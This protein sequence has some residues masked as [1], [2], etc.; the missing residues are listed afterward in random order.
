MG[1]EEL[2]V[3]MTKIKNSEVLEL[4]SKKE[5]CLEI[6][7]NKDLV[8][9]FGRTTSGKSST[10]NS[11]MGTKYKIE[12]DS[13]ELEEGSWN[14]FEIGEVGGDSCTKF[15]QPCIHPDGK[16]VF[17]DTR[18]YFDT[19]EDENEEIVS[20]ILIEMAVK[21]A[22]SVR[23]IM[24]ER[25]SI[26]FQGLSGF[27]NVGK[28]ITKIAVSS[29]NLT[30]PVLF[31]FNR[32]S[33]PTNINEMKKY[34]DLC[35]E[36][37]EGL[38]IIEKIK[39]ASKHM[40]DKG[41]SHG[42]KE[43]LLYINLIKNNFEKENFGYIDPTSP[44][45]INSLY[46]KILQL[47]PV[48]SNDLVFNKSN[49]YRVKF[50]T[51][52]EME[53]LSLLPI[54]ESKLQLFEYTPEFLNPIQKRCDEYLIQLENDFHICNEIKKK[55]D[56]DDEDNNKL[57]VME[58]KYDMNDVV[59]DEVE[60]QFKIS[61][62]EATNNIEELKK[63]IKSFDE[64]Y[65]K[66]FWEYAFNEHGFG[67]FHTCEVHYDLGIPYADFK[68]YLGE[69]THRSDVIDIKSPNFHVK[70]SSANVKKTMKKAGEGILKGASTGA[71]MTVSTL[72]PLV[73]VSSA[74]GSSIGSAIGNIIIGEDCYGIIKI[75]VLIK[76]I[77][78]NK[79]LLEIKQRKLENI[80]NQRRE[81]EEEL[82]SLKLRSTMDVINKI[83]FD[84]EIC[85]K[86]QNQ[87]KKILKFKSDIDNYFE[88]RKNDI[89]ICY[90]IIQKLSGGNMVSMNFS[91]IY[92]KLKMILK[93]KKDNLK[94]SED[95]K[96]WDDKRIREDAKIIDKGF[97]EM[98]IC[99]SDMK[100]MF[101]D[102][103]LIE[104]KRKSIEKI[105][106][107]YDEDKIDEIIFKMFE[108]NG[109]MKEEF[110]NYFNEISESDFLKN[111]IEISAGLKGDE[112][113]LMRR[114]DYVAELIIK[115]RQLI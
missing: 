63:E 105:I 72:N 32:F 56:F 110:Q 43:E 21:V 49:K 14:I 80:K 68:E 104:K 87:I 7:K 34:L 76:N 100:Y 66:P 79:K 12:E 5:S 107:L 50:N 2:L 38:F 24:I 23:I 41:L 62:D 94:I 73:I 69:N 13:L 22:K 81:N 53:L 58:Q 46:N 36:G 51:L 65:P 111:I 57:N 35:E 103:E 17:L 37:K 85:K 55:T 101:S 45:S 82:L 16:I 4:I 70:Y 44:I 25:Y 29:E 115:L 74:I 3:T 31:L 77:P 75:Y 40:I 11:L 47:S 54:V 106:N 88:T 112:K 83:K 28:M 19:I 64:I 33:P 60:T 9:F 97:N 92:F 91:N 89:E 109:E 99:E 48:K 98:I 67:L 102:K 6:C 113:Y 61:I 39:T 114:N 15:P 30:I 93:K 86:R 26:L 59:L 71:L 84:I 95:E 10:I 20:S 8:I 78:E 52:F 90:E 18:G 1:V 42:K 27:N 96:G 108:E